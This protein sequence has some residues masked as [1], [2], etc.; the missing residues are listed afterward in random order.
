MIPHPM[1]VTPPAGHRWPSK[2]LRRLYAVIEINLLLWLAVF[3]MVYRGYEDAR[4]WAAGGLVFSAVA[5]H[6]AYYAV[7][8][9]DR[10]RE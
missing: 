4:L 1:P 3:S 10:L 5:Q 2:V 7:R 9:A 8:K 6:W